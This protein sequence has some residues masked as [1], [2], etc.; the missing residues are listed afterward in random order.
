MLKQVLEIIDIIDRGNVCGKDIVQLFSGYQNVTATWETVAGESGTTDFVKIVVRGKNGKS[1]GGASPNLG[2]IGRL[3]G[4]GARPSHIGMVSD[5]DGAVSAL[6]V[7]LKLAQM[8][9]YE[10]RL[11]GDV[12]ITTHICPNAPSEPHFPVD[13]MGSPVDMEQMNTYEVAAEADAFLT[14]D[15]TKGND[16]ITHKGYSISPTV[17]EGYILR[18]SQDLLDIMKICSGIA[19]S[20]FPLSLLDITPYSNNLYH[21]NII[22]QPSTATNAP[23]VGVAITTQTVVPGC[24]TGASHEGDICEASRFVVEVAKQFTAGKLAFYDKEEFAKLL[25][26]YGPMNKFQTGGSI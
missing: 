10:D 18:V 5:A 2:V 14:I 4:I 17:K 25:Q 1:S 23:V 11:E 21:I 20:T 9:L 8:T 3:G 19:P 22:L 7:A 12:I 26:L 13:F 16:V 24:A 15:T 6:S